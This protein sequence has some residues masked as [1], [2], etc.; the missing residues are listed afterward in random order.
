MTDIQRLRSDGRPGEA[1]SPEQSTPLGSGALSLLLT[2]GVCLLAVMLAAD[3]ASARPHSSAT[4][5]G[6]R[7]VKPIKPHSHVPA[8]PGLRGISSASHST[9]PLRGKRPGK[10]RVKARAAGNRAPGAG[11]ASTLILYDT[12]GPYGWMGELYGMYAANLASHFGTWRAEPVARYTAGM[13]DAHTATI[14]LGSTYDEPLPAAFLDDVHSTT[15]PVIWV[16]D[17]IWQLASRH[18]DFSVK[19]GWQWAGFDTSD[20]PR[21]SYKGTTLTRSLDNRG[22]IM[23]YANLDPAKVTTLATAERS[24]GT[25]FPWAVRSA[26]LTYIGDNPFSYTSETDRELIFAD[27]LF[28]ALAPQQTERHRALVRIEDISPAS[29]PDNLRAVA[30]TLYARRIPFGFGVSPLYRDPNGAV[31]PSKRRLLLKNAPGVV[32][33][34]RYMQ[35]RGGVMINHGYTHQYSNLKNPYDG[36]S[37][38]DFEFYRV[39][40]NAD[41]TLNFAGPVPDDSLSWA[42]NRMQSANRAFNAAGFSSPRIFE[43][44]HYTAS[45]NAYR[46]AAQLFTTRW[47]RGMY[48]SGLL[49]GGT[50]DYQRPIGQKFPYVVRDVYGST[51]LPENIGSYEPEAFHQFPVHTVDDIVAGADANRV[52]RD[53]FASFYFHPFWSPEPLAEAL[54]RLRARGWTFVSPTTLM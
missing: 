42:R 39:T 32:G 20:V 43:F 10:T 29:D 45:V 40:E 53:G 21:V 23:A 46:A 49:R 19:Y 50:I 36:V 11:S 41:H 54:D 48:F 9:R 35:E 7:L 30:D 5:Q 24:T 33:A 26:N 51:V 16:Y 44:P 8:L 37:G 6:K 15:K 38:N 25:S 52:V 18:A 34:I 22:G 13:V 31:D 17:N 47:E 2:L 14:Y 27:L 28:D 4:T 12:T 3:A 1:H